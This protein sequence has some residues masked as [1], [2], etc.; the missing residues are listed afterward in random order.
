MKGHP[1][2]QLRSA[3]TSYNCA[4]LVF[5]NRRTCVEPMCVP[6]ILRRDGYRQIGIRQ[7]CRGDVVLYRTPDD[8]VQH[9]GILIERNPD[10]STGTWRMS[11]L[12]QWGLG[13]EFIH[14]LEDVPPL[15]GE[16]TEAWTDRSAM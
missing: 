16:P 9:V 8:E 3:S 7:A 1:S 14:D 4:G 6:E 10:Y 2:V 11:V 13:G 15:F 5:A 12:S